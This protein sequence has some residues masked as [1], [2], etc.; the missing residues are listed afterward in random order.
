M[1]TLAANFHCPP[2]QARSR[3]PQQPRAASEEWLFPCAGHRRDS[4]RM[5]PQAP[6]PALGFFHGLRTVPR[7]LD[8]L[9]AVPRLLG[10][11]LIPLA[12]TL[13]LDGLVLRYGLGWL[14]GHLRALLPQQTL[15]VLLDILAG[16]LLVIILAWTFSFVF[17]AFCE[18][19]VDQVS[20]GVEEHL[21][22]QAGSA[23][24]LGSLLR[25]L[26][27][28]LLQSMFA[29]TLGLL[30]LLLNLIPILGTLASLGL[31]ALLLGY[32]FFSVSAGRKG[33]SLSQRLSLLWAHL[34]PVLGLGSAVMLINLI[35]VLN[36]LALPVFVVAGTILFLD[37]TLPPPK[38]PAPAAG[39]AENPA[40]P[41]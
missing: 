13:I 33:L 37:V 11:L 40:Q 6:R 32:G 25:G 3:L 5:A 22:G 10:W 7:A 9:Q 23:A 30:G 19:V 26:L 1:A 12:L 14:H 4:Q 28:S 38:P 21:T 20:E 39:G 35:P 15:G 34:A 16:I 24:G 36:L 41:G 2:K 29:A 31:S 8:V 18:L 17:L 27:F